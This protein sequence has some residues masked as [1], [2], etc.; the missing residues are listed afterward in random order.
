MDDRPKPET[1]SVEGLNEIRERLPSCVSL[2]EW[3]S[4]HFGVPVGRLMQPR[5]D[6]ERLDEVL[7]GSA[8]AGLRLIYWFS[9]E[10]Q[11]VPAAITTKYRGKMVDQRTTFRGR[12]DALVQHS[13]PGSSGASVD[14]YPIGPA[15]E[16]LQEL[17]VVAGQHSRFMVDPYIP[18][19]RGAALFRFWVDN[20]TRHENADVCFV[21]WRND[22][23]V[24]L[25]TAAVQDRKA[26]IGLIAI[27]D[28]AR[29]RNIGSQLLATAHRW[30]A[31]R[32]AET[33]EVTTQWRNTT[34]CNFYQKS[35]YNLLSR[36][37]V[38]HFWPEVAAI[39]C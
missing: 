2:L 10:K 8:I 3:D 26:S 14:E 13:D 22:E 7:R 9:D 15:S 25:V 6:P 23:S 21:A 24:G 38:Y 33:S 34:A 17:G 16:Q 31:E 18:S 32:S 28:Q 37:P 29:R 20:S 11:V 1:L 4:H 19:D 12:L 39:D 5:Y 27:A 36:T 30:M 35:G